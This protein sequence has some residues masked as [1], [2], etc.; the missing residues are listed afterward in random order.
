MLSKEKIIEKVDT[1]IIDEVS[2]LR[3]DILEGIDFSLRKNGGNPHELF[4]GKQLILVGDIFNYHLLFK[5][6]MKSNQIYS[7]LYIKA[8][9]FSTL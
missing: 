3:S 8:S 9:T 7:K 4:G 6:V 2:M 5:Q 1:I